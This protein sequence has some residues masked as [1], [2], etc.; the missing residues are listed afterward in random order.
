MSKSARQVNYSKKDKVQGSENG[1]LESLSLIHPNHSEIRANIPEELKALPVWVGWLVSLD[2]QSSRVIKRP[3]NPKTGDYAKSNDPSTWGLFDQAL[4]GCIKFGYQYPGIMFDGTG[5]VGIDIDHCINENGEISTEAQEI[6]DIVDSYTELSP[7][8][9]GVH[10]LTMG[11]KPEG[12]CRKD[13]IEMYDKGRGFTITGNCI[14]NPRVI[15]DRS[16][17]VNLVHSRFITGELGK[18]ARYSHIPFT[19]TEQI[20]INAALKSRN[21]GKIKALLNGDYSLYASQSEADLALCGYLGKYTKGSAVLVDSIFRKSG[22]YRRKWDELRGQATYGESTIQKALSSYVDNNLMGLSPQDIGQSLYKGTASSSSY[23][24]STDDTGN[25]RR[26]RDK[27]GERIRFSFSENVWR[28]YDGKRWLIDN[29]GEIKR[30][31]DEVIEDMITEPLEEGINYANAFEITRH[32]KRTK[33]SKGKEAMIKEAQ[34]LEGISVIPDNFDTNSE[35]FNVVNGTLDLRTGELHA[36][37]SMDM[38]TKLAPIVYDIN[39]KCPLWETFVSRVFNGDEELIRFFKT[40]VGYSLTGYNQ[41]QCMFILYGEGQNGKSTAVE[42]IMHIMGDYAI[43]ASPDTFLTRDRSGSATPDIVRLNG[44]RFVS[45]TEPQEGARLNESLIKQMTG[46]DTI[47][48]RALY[49][50]AIQFKPVFKLWMTTNHKPMV[51]GTDEGIWRRIRLIPF[52][53]RIP[54]NQR[55]KELPNKLLLEASGILNWMIEGH[56]LYMRNGL[57]MPKSV[58]DATLEYR[59]EMDTLIKF[60]DECLINDSVSFVK[61]SELY[62]CYRMWLQK[63]S[64]Q[65]YAT[66]AKFFRD[67]NK[68]IPAE[69]TRTGSIYQGYAFSVEGAYLM[70]RNLCD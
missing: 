67:L 65:K 64:I 29:L 53:Y 51:S 41:E 47:T 40:S 11:K 62:H 18:E 49:S 21:R 30:M 63:N 52:S 50:K 27:F 23:R 14:R 12:G 19:E 42:T 22:L 60:V 39:A 10:I 45:T 2:K 8:G 59:S 46:N 1:L 32:I 34:H 54:E 28:I 69:H 4:D 5:V 35:L 7:S 61:S 66:Q 70:R 24:Y 55:D 20:I 33:S 17:E 36:H 16:A 6:I 25:A 37:N 3:I 57:A 68:R 38:I 44:A 56:K 9:K 58:L 13:N 31:A 48:A 43:S 26:L 15:W